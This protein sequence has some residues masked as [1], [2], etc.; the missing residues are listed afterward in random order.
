MSDGVKKEETWQERDARILALNIAELQDAQRHRRMIEALLED[1]NRL[2][3]RLIQA[4]GDQARALEK[5]AASL[6]KAS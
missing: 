5:I 3:E 1:W 6:G 4:Q 2:S